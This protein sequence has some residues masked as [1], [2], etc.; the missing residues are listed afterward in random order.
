MVLT[1][2]KKGTQYNREKV[3]TPK[4]H[5]PRTLENTAMFWDLCGF[6][7]NPKRDTPARFVI[8]ICVYSYEDE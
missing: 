3:L 8:T 2:L 5:I 4:T 6:Q 7:Y 1:T